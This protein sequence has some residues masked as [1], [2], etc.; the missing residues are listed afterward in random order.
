[1]QRWLENIKEIRHNQLL[2]EKPQ[3]IATKMG[4]RIPTDNERN[5]SQFTGS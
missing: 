1:M 2:H 4:P 5:P 3:E